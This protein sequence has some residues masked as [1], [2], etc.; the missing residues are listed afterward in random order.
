MFSS[1]KTVSGLTL[2]ILFSCHIDVGDVGSMEVHVSGNRWPAMVAAS[3]T[4]IINDAFSF[5]IPVGQQHRQP[6]PHDIKVP[7]LNRPSTPPIFSKAFHKVSRKRFR[8]K[9][10]NNWSLWRIP[11]TS[12]VFSNPWDCIEKGLVFR[13]SEAEEMDAGSHHW[14]NTG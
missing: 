11:S 8:G 1:S 4:P 14:I 13:V 7:P 6:A 12:R 5:P 10:R 9:K 3:P 2:V